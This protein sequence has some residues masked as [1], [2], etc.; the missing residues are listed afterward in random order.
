MSC[1]TE[2]GGLSEASTN[3]GAQ[4]FLEPSEAREGKEGF[5]P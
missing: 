4:G 1:E 2:G 5:S 3:P